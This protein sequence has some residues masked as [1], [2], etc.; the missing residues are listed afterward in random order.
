[1]WTDLIFSDSPVMLL[2]NLISYIFIPCSN[3]DGPFDLLPFSLPKYHILT[4]LKFER[5]KYTR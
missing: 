2:C 5:V 1:M 3:E 4:F